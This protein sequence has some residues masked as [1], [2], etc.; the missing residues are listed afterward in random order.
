MS[1]N[2]VIDYSNVFLGNTAI[3]ARDFFDHYFDRCK[4]QPHV[5][6]LIDDI[7]DQPPRHQPEPTPE[8]VAAQQ[9]L[10]EHFLKLTENLPPA[11]IEPLPQIFTN[12]P[13]QIDD[14]MKARFAKKE[15]E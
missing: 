9:E 1:K 8:Q 10:L 15:G 14:T 3:R 6:M 12:N 2:E 5:F 7:D 11:P 4:D 13:A